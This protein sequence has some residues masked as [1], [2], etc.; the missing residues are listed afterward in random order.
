MLY[1]NVSQ[2]MVGFLYLKITKSV[3]E[4]ADYSIPEMDTSDGWTTMWMYF[5]EL[6]T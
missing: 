2:N 6:Y 4:K 3:V 1:I 5:T